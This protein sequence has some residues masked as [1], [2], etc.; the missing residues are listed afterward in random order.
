MG[1]L[2]QGIAPERFRVAE[3]CVYTAR[4]VTGVHCSYEIDGERV[5]EPPSAG[6]PS[7]NR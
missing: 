4:L 3:I 5:A 1:R 2:L 7:Q 6:A